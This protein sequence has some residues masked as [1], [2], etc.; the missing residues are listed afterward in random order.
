MRPW[1]PF[2]LVAT[3]VSYRARRL[4][5]PAGRFS[6]LARLSLVALSASMSFGC[7]IEDPPPYTQP[8]KTRPNLNLANS[9]PPP[10]Q[11]IVR[12]TNDPIDF[13]VPFVSEDAGDRVEGALLLDFAGASGAEFLTN[14]RVDA[15]T[16]DD[17]TRELN[18]SWEVSFWVPSGCVRFTLRVSHS[19]NFLGGGEVIDE[20]DVSEAYWWANIN[21][22]TDSNTLVNCPVAGGAP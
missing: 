2:S 13:R 14:A 6:A 5:A 9:F 21:P 11:V 10:D 8:E 7:L 22:T 20:G 12:E 3:R 17:D 18:V 4:A 15:S 1:S 19:S 16:L